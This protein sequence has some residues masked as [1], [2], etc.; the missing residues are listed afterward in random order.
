MRYVVTNGTATPL[1]STLYESYGKTGT[2]EFSSDKNK[3][4]SWFVGFARDA[5]GKEIAIA[6]VMEGVDAG[7][8]YA[9]PASKMILDAY[10]GA[11]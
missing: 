1:N 8:S 3:D 2:A 6:V 4:H 10:F 9:V 5:N 11:Q 7:N